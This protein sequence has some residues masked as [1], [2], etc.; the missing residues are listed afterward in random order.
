MKP[1]NL[2]RTGSIVR[3]CAPVWLVLMCAAA[4]HAAPSPKADKPAKNVD[5]KLL[6][7]YTDMAKGLQ[8]EIAKTLPIMDEGKKAALQQARDAVK[9]ATAG[10]KAGQQAQDKI[11]TAKAL[12]DHAKGKWLGGAEKGIAKAEA[13]LKKATTEAE[14]EAAKKELAKWQ[15]DKEAGLKALKERQEAYDKLRL[16]EPQL[17]EA[18]QKAQGTAAQAQAG[19]L[20]AARAILADLAPFLASDKLD[21]NLV[22]CA[23]LVNATPRGLAE[24]AQEGKEQAALVEK[25]LADTLLMKEMLEAGG[26]N[27]GKYGRAVQIYTDIQKASPRAGE[28]ILH[29]LALGTSLEHAVPVGQRNAA[30]NTNAPTVVDPVKRYLHYE[31]AYLDGE[32]DPAFKN[33]TAWECRYITDSDAPD[34]VLAWGRAMLRN[35]RPDHI[36]N[37]DYGWRYSGIVRTDVAYRHSQDYK[38]T[39]SLDFY[40]NVIKNG[41]ICGRRAWFGGFML[42]CFGIPSVRRPQPGHAALAHWTPSGWVV[43]LGAGWGSGSVENS[44]DT[45]FLLETQ[46]RKYPKDY[47]KV[48]RAQWAGDALGEQKYS[49][50]KGGSG[51]WWNVVAMYEKKAIVAEAKPVQ[52]AALGAELG[53][54]NESAETRAKAVE[55]AAISDADKKIVTGPNGAITIPAAACSGSVHQMKSFLGGLQAFCGGPFSCTVEA[56]NPGKYQLTARVVA[57]HDEAHLPLAP[58]NARN[59]IDVVIPYTCGQWQVTKPVEITLVQGKNVLSFSKPTSNFTVKD[60]LLTPVK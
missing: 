9:K 38:D 19:E 22:K 34:H 24:F 60:L 21:A 35:Y 17:A 40:Q 16:E 39:D 29:R 30:A 49:S 23:V 31:K 27:G 11:R 1:A 44:P 45:E 7:Q 20:A 5:Q 57:V 28:G 42:R 26:A 47:L 37:S 36:F 3:R 4:A 13:A 43:N 58:N 48:L 46:V 25:L 6:A 18:N 52:L 41:G 55:A 10:T 51:G 8:A 14:R 53:E 12:V 59:P 33:M 54:A 15:A 50:Q 56:A 32:L 2:T